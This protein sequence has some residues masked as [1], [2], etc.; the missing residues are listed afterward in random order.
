MPCETLPNDRYDIG[1]G[2]K[3]D[4]F[5]STVQS[6]GAMNAEGLLRSMLRDSHSTGGVLWA[7]QT[8]KRKGM[9]LWRRVVGGMEVGSAECALLEVC[10]PGDVEA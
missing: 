7:V 10:R 5:Q 3:G 4:S 9:E 8:W 1:G 6:G 2:E